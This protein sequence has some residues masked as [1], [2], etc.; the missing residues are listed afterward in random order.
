MREKYIIYGEKNGRRE[1]YKSER[2][3]E[4]VKEEVKR[5]NQVD[6]GVTYGYRQVNQVKPKNPQTNRFY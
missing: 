4:T 6:D 5:L 2:G 1:D 3:E